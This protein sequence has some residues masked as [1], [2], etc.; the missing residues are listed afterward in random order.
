MPSHGPS[1]RTAA[2][3]RAAAVL[4]VVTL[5]VIVPTG[6]SALL[7]DYTY[8]SFPNGNCAGTPTMSQPIDSVGSAQ[9]SSVVP[10]GR[11]TLTDTYSL[12]SCT[13]DGSSCTYLV[14]EDSG[15]SAPCAPTIQTTEDFVYNC[16]ADNTH[17]AVAITRASFDVQW[18]ETFTPGTCYQYALGQ[19]RLLESSHGSVLIKP[20]SLDKDQIAVWLVISIAMFCG[21]CV[22]LPLCY[23]SFKKRA[24]PMAYQSVS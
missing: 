21:C 22:V 12:F 18:P 23:C 17:E 3:R 20:P 5:T 4:S 13:S 10:C 24:A 9:Q 14:C 11:G 2:A 19:N 16:I 1:A 7:T 8:E 6:G 15:G